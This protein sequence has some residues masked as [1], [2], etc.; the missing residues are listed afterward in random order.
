MN[1]G[2]GIEGGL[3]YGRIDCK[4]GGEEENGERMRAARRRVWKMELL[5][6]NRCVFVNGCAEWKSVEK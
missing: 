6:V 3:R 2:D 1:N 4:G 5:L